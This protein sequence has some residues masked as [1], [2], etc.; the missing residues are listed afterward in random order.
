MAQG[1]VAH[2]AAAAGRAKQHCVLRDG[3]KKAGSR[4][5]SMP[6]TSLSHASTAKC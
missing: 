1:M 5:A 2:Q 3:R 6:S 4:Q